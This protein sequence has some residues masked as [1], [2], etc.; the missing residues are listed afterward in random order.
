[1]SAKT[2][3]EALHNDSYHG[4][5][6]TNLNDECKPPMILFH[7]DECCQGRHTW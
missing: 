7:I 5:P 3:T 1:M 4:E 6:E 2:I